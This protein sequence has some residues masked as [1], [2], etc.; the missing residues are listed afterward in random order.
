M[1]IPFGLRTTDQCMVDPTEVANGKSCGCC[2]PECG[3]ELIARQGEIQTWHFAHQ[4]NAHCTGG[5]ESAIHRMAKQMIMQRSQ[6]WVPQRRFDRD[7]LGS[8]DDV[9]GG[10]S[11]KESLSF[12]VS[13]EGVK[14]LSECREEERVETRRPDLLAILEGQPIAIEIAYTHFC[15]EEKLGWLKARNLTTLEIDVGISPD[16]EMSDIRAILEVRLFSSTTFT[17]WLVHSGDSAAFSQLEKAA[18]QLRMV[19]AEKDAS[20]LKDVERKRA[21]KKS[22][23]EF[24]ASIKDIDYWTHKINRDLTL[25]VAYS[26]IRCTLSW[27]GNIKSAPESLKDAPLKLARKYGGFYNKRFSIWE[28]RVPE[29]KAEP[30]YRKMIAFMA[31]ALTESALPSSTSPTVRK[32]S[33]PNSKTAP[34]QA[35]QF[36]TPVFQSSVD[37]ET[38]RERAAILEFEN[39]VSREEAERM[40]AREILMSKA[41]GSS[42]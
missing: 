33:A 30:L 40:A 25:R 13:T 42:K 38:F 6:V 4:S 39:K 16:T 12:V 23:D 32:V 24:K 29:D 14:T 9:D 3:E 18:Q 26:K 22:I 17:T 36:V 41:F 7:I 8:R 2:C 21:N 31:S 10:Y 20:F 27:H 11:W 5:Y 15:D 19:N 37:N 28:Y 35:T 1:K 34:D